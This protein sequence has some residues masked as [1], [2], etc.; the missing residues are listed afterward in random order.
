ML[1]ITVWQENPV[2]FLTDNFSLLTKQETNYCKGTKMVYFTFTNKEFS[3]HI[4]CGD[5]IPE[6]YMNMQCDEVQATDDELEAVKN[7]TSGIKTITGRVVTFVGDDAQFLFKNRLQI[8]NL[9][10]VVR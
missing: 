4:G 7:N 1:W 8:F 5:P 2:L 6:I 10:R 3:T 9:K